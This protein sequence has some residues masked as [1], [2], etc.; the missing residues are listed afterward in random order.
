MEFKANDR[1]YSNYIWDGD[2]DAPTIDPVNEKII[3]GDICFGRFIQRCSPYRSKSIPGVLVLNGSTFGRKKN[4]LFYKCIPNDKS[5]PVFLVPFED[6]NTSF[7]KRKLNRFVSFKFLNWEAKHPEGQLIETIGYV[8]DIDAY[9][10]YMLRCKDISQP[11]QKF[12]KD[13]FKSIVK[14]GVDL[15]NVLGNKPY[16]DRRNEYIM[17]IDPDGCEDIDDAF[18][19]K[20]NDNGSI[21]LSVYIA[22]VPI[23]LDYLDLW[24]HIGARVS[25]I[26]L[27]DRQRPMLPAALSS[28]LCS[29]KSGTDKITLCMDVVIESGQ[30]INTTFNVALVNLSNN[31][32][33]EQCELSN[34]PGYKLAMATII[35]LN[36]K[37]HLLD[38]ITDSHELVQYMMLLMNIE[39]ATKLSKTDDGI[40]R[41]LQVKSSNELPSSLPKDITTIARAW[42]SSGGCY[43]TE[44]KVHDLIGS[45]LYAHITS[46]IRRLIDVYN[47]CAILEISG[48]EIDSTRIKLIKDS[49]DWVNKDMKSIRRVQS[50]VEI[51][52]DVES[53]KLSGPQEGYI[54]DVD[55]NSW[56]VYFPVVRKVCTC[57]TDA[58][59][60]TYEKRLFTFHSF[61][62]E[63]NL[64]KKVR[65]STI[66]ENIIQ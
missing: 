29:L 15:E 10:E 50:D 51:L 42:G 62:D 9:C 49:L 18:S 64:R 61:I 48:Y 39:A 5:L 27:P 4:K 57:K 11:I 38:T 1:G 65:I 25:T 33:Y 66:E 52:V 28:G 24:H 45:R 35:D 40:F 43:T 6:K 59:A 26:Y 30:I 47:M 17:S 41:S 31:F 16:I 54:I 20:K 21:T 37:N 55:E 14:K 53:G 34:A 56:S 46:P 3:T 22:N 58:T 13:T 63:H 8:S 12:T 60:M 7:S 36:N 23:W 44:T 32:A 2:G 19:C